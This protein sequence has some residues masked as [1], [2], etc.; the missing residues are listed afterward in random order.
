MPHIVLLTDIIKSTCNLPNKWV[1]VY[2]PHGLFGTNYPRVDVVR[3]LSLWNI[4]KCK[5][6]LLTF[7]N[8]FDQNEYFFTT[9]T[10]TSMFINPNY[11]QVSGL[12]TFCITIESHEKRKYFPKL[13]YLIKLYFSTICTRLIVSFIV[14]RHTRSS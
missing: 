9:G 1:S 14:A 4:I 7:V 2:L 12:S 8:F 11:S 5:V 3:I 6:Y 13:Y 10:A